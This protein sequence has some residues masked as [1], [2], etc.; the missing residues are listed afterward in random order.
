[1]AEIQNIQESWEGHTGLEVEQFIKREV[2]NTITTLGSKFGAVAYEEGQ[3]KFY[4]EDNGTLLRT[5]SLT[6]TSYSVNVATDKSPTF[7][8]LTNDES[9]I[10]S[11]TPSTSAMEIGSPDKEDFLE[12]YTFKLEVDNGAGFVD[13]TPANNTIKNK[14][15]IGVEVRSNLTVGLN[16]VRIIVTGNESRQVRAM[17]FAVTLTSLTFNC[18]HAWYQVWFEGAGYALTSIYLGGNI[19]KKLNVKIGENLYHQDYP[20]STQYVSTPTSF[21]VADKEPVESGII[22]VELWLSGEGVETEHFHFNIMFVKKEDIGKVSLICTNEVPAKIYN[23]TQ[24]TLLKYAT[25]EVRNLDIDIAYHQGESTTALPTTSIEV[26]PQQPYDLPLFVQYDTNETSDLSV[27]VSIAGGGVNVSEIIALDNSTAFLPV[28]GAKFTLN[29]SLGN[30]A[31]TDKESIINS[32]P[33]SEGYQAVYDTEAKGFTFSD[34]MWSVDADGNKALV[35]KAGA[36]LK[37]NDLKPLKATQAGSATFEFMFRASNIADY[38]TPILTCINTETYDKD[39]SVGIVVLPTKVLVLGK[40]KRGFTLQQLPLSENRIHHIAVVIQRAFA[41]QS[42]RNLCRVFL[43]GCENVAFDFDGTDTFYVSGD[44]ED[45][46]LHIGQTSTDTYLYMARIYERALEGRDVFANYLNAVIESA[47]RGRLGL[48]K[49]NNITENNAVIYDLCKK[50]GFNCYVIETDKELPSLNNNTA[51][52]Q[53]EAANGTYPTGINVH[54]EYNDHPEWNVSIY[55]VP[56]DGQGTTSK[57]YHW[58]NMR[59]NIKKPVRWVY[60]NM[61]DTSTGKP[62]EEWNKAGYLAGYKAAPAVSKITNKK[63]IASQ[64]QGHKMGA[65]GFYND[66]YKLVMGGGDKLVADGILPSKGARVAVYQ[67]PF[68]GFQKYSD[69]TYRFIGLFTGGPDKTDKKT[70]GYNETDKFPRLMMVEGPNH[71]PY[72]T[73][74]LVPWTDDVFYDYKNETLSVGD[75]NGSKQEGWDADIVADL[76]NDEEGDVAAVMELYESEFKPAYDAVYYNSPYIASLAESGY[77]L[78]Q[79]N[80]NVTEFQAGFT[81]G[82]KNNL[83]TF[84]N[85]AYELIYYRVKTKQYEVLPKSKYDML[86][87]LGLTVPTT[88]DI[89]QARASRWAEQIGQYVNLREAYYHQCFCELLGVSDNDAK[90]TYWRKF[91]ALSEGGKWGFN[92]DDLDTIFQNDNNGQ[93]TKPYYVEPDDTVDGVDIFQGRTSAFWYALRLHSKDAMLGMMHDIISAVKSIAQSNNLTA[94]TIHETFL[95]VISFY[96]WDKSSKY[97]P[98]TA[99]N[100]DTEYAYINVWFKDPAKVYNNVPPLTQVHGDHYETEREWVEKRIAYMFSKYQIGA[101]DAENPD[102]Y[103]SLNFTPK[104]SFTMEV[105]PAI[106]IYPR[107]SVGGARTERETQRTKAGEKCNLILPSDSATGVYIKGFD[108]LSDIGDIS[109]M[110]IT[111]RSTS[112]ENIPFAL[113]GKR[114][115]KVKIGDVNGDVK[116]NA[117]NL[118]ISGESIE[119]I[120][121]RNASSVSQTLDLKGCPRLRKA[122]FGGT[123]LSQVTFPIGGRIT[124]I[125]LP[126]SNTSLILNNLSLLEPEG[127]VLSDKA[128][129]NTDTLYIENC[130]KLQPFDLLFSLYNKQDG[131][132][133]NI[134]IVWMGEIIND[135]QESFRALGEIARNEKYSGIEYVNGNPNITNFPNINGILRLNHPVYER[136][137]DAVKN[138]LVNLTVLYDTSKVYIEF[139]DPEV[140]SKLATALGDGTGVTRTVAQSAFSIP[141]F[142]GDT[143]IVSFRELTE[144]TS[145]ETLSSRC[146]SGCSNLITI[147]ISKLKS[148][149]TFVFE[150]CSK[151]ESV[152]DVSG[153]TKIN[154]GAFKQCAALKSVNISDLCTNIGYSAFE[155][156]TSLNHVGDLSSVTFIGEYAFKG[157]SSLVTELDLPALKQMDDEAF[158]GAG[159][160]AL[161]S[162]GKVVIISI[163]AFSE[164]KKLSSVF[165]HEGVTHIYSAAFY[166]CT[167]LTVVDLPSTIAEIRIHAFLGCS[168]LKYFICRS[169][170]PPTLAATSVIPNNTDLRIYVPDSSVEAYKGASNWS[171]HASKIRPLSEYSG[172]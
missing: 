170:I 73:R 48:Q 19:A 37:I 6:G 82:H 68:F 167:A 72:M 154:S 101:F 39:K 117:N 24:A 126:D 50:A 102:G 103:G 58:W 42:D 52:D 85:D 47:E 93:D 44:T 123:S 110:A 119:E 9:C 78:E 100:G 151:M 90:N 25:Y 32:A 28:S 164:C 136:D 83:M 63:N 38:D 62:I 132:L 142:Q 65:T 36:T 66:A 144:F 79:I 21:N 8:V 111:S 124:H 152:G 80:A 161:R 146:F 109:Q 121:A 140:E 91:K 54:Y 87:D 139:E 2:S 141:S 64:P 157:C 53:V 70:F 74:F 69:G 92:Q 116:F 96:F 129:A 14:E 71:S 77:T 56:L 61:K 114:L 4:D 1:M 7:N 89:L 143:S 55:D 168:K 84:Y 88:E 120:D 23:F 46:T 171:G 115:R 137:I 35:V 108:W 135:K 125:E 147:D 112:T 97:F 51:Y 153:F 33:V 158:K 155:G 113:S 131:K 60:P 128:F 156:C 148:L 27:S 30:N 166:L 59:H 12:D 98:A 169:E 49:D 105:T 31:S 163:N 20:A 57:L 11:I 130:P 122:Y 43:N 149:N 40:V 15:T 13:R 16:R 106:D 118:T 145:V 29:P 41:G 95:N 127:L 76:A 81:N 67:H 138:K 34:D 10:I 133:T 159:V 18:T 165:L 160:T 172:V 134:G 22:P 86:I 150:N 5:V 104:G 3:I 26:T 45:N 75:P 17:G 107:L 99:Y 94:S 162:L